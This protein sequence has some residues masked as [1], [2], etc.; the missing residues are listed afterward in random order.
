MR[1]VTWLTT[2][3]VVVGLLAAGAVG[4]ALFRRTL[5]RAEIQQAVIT[6]DTVSQHKREQWNKSLSLSVA[7]ISNEFERQKRSLELTDFDAI[8][9]EIK[10]ASDTLADLLG[11]SNP[12]TGRISSVNLEDAVR[13][14]LSK[15]GS[16]MDAVREE[17]F[18]L[19]RGGFDSWARAKVHAASRSDEISNL[20]ADLAREQALIAHPLSQFVARAVLHKHRLGVDILPDEVKTYSYVLSN[21]DPSIRESILRL[22]NS[23]LEAKKIRERQELIIESHGWDAIEKLRPEL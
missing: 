8:D 6:Q 14:R 12:F 5:Q 7:T 1:V 16:A 18:V 3:A 10:R 15:D 17:A 19:E 22:E 23:G 20:I 2:A 11:R 21:A 4:I 9:H 13:A